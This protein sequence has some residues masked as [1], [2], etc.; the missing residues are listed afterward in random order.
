MP[1][2]F[3]G[4]G[5]ADATHMSN[6]N[7]DLVGGGEFGKGFYTQYAERHARAW[8]LRVRQRLN[9]AP[10]VLELD[11]DAVAYGGLSVLWLDAKLG[12]NLTEILD[13]WNA[14]ATFTTGCCDFLEG[15]IMGN[16]M[17]MQ[18]KFESTNAMLLLNGNGTQRSVI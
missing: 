2:L 16:M 4:T 7:I 12:P 3:H 5:H 8:A 6:G 9:G 15:P 18:Q 13:H 17:R 10:V 11:I 14:K 1:T